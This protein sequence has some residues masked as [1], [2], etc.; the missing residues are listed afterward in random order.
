MNASHVS[1]LSRGPV[2]AA[3][4][5]DV[6]EWVRK[7]GIVVWLDADNHYTAFVD[8]LV[9]ARTAGQLPYEVRAFHGSFLDLML[10]LEG[11]AG[12]T[13]KV[14]LLVHLPG[15]TEESVK[16]TPVRSSRERSTRRSPHIR[17]VVRS[18]RA[19]R[20]GRSSNETR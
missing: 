18:I 6:R 8:A 12:G 14:R 2:S 7:H 4:E 13:E 9:A 10:A 19:L 15:F 11:V 16:S 20:S 1:Q 3:L 5:T 17:N